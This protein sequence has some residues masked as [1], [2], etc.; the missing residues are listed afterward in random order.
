M[1]IQSLP[2]DTDNFDSRYRL[3][4]LTAQRARHIAHG[5]K[6]FV[7]T[8]YTKNTTIAIQEA[9]SGVLEYVTGED[10]KKEK[11]RARIYKREERY[12]PEEELT[13]LE[14]DLKVYLQEKA[15]LSQKDV[16]GIL[17][18]EH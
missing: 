10:A 7:E 17:E 16:R 11:E 9:I 12:T 3:V 2:I 5:E 6:P 15:E 4:H 14:K 8:K 18:E 13:E 1:D